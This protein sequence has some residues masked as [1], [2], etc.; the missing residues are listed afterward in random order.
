MEV[1]GLLIPLQALQ[2]GGTGVSFCVLV[3]GIS[4][5]VAHEGLRAGCFSTG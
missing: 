1:N 2:L 5:A 4:P 3:L